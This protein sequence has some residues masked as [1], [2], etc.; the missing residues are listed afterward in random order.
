MYYVSRCMCDY[1]YVYVYL[2]FLFVYLCI[3]LYVHVYGY[4]CEFIIMWWV[5]VKM[6]FL[7]KRDTVISYKKGSRYLSVVCT[8]HGGGKS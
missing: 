2:G 8:S 5:L 6:F 1:M 7:S 3:Y 4:G